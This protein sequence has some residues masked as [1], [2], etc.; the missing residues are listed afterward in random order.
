MRRA[1]IAGL[2][3]VLMTA[4]GVSGAVFLQ[5]DKLQKAFDDVPGGRVDIKVDEITPAEAGKPQTIMILGTDERLGADATPGQRPR[6]DTILL[7]RL[8]AHKESI[9]LMSIPRDF[10]V[11]IP[12]YSL[13]DKINA[14]FSNGG[15]DLTL[16]T[17]KALLSRPDRPFKV[18]HVVQVSFTGFRRMVDYLG[19][20]YVDIDRRYF[21]DVSGPGGYA[22]IDIQPGYQKL[23]GKDALDY[24]RF[25]HTD[26][27]LVRGARQQDFV[28]Q[29]LRQPGVRKRLTLSKSEALIRLVGRYTKVDKSLRSKKQLFSLFKLG[30]AVANKPIQEVPFGAGRIEDDGPSYL[31]ASTDAIDETVNQFLNSRPADKPR[32]TIKDTPAEK[33]AKRKARKKAKSAGVSGLEND[34][35]EGENMAIVAKRHLDFPFYYPKLRVVGSRYE[36]QLPRFYTIRDELGKKHRAYR[37]VFSLGQAGEYYGVQGMSWMKPPILDGP[38]ETDRLNGRRFRV[39]FD[40]KRV[41]LVAW[42]TDNAVYWVHNTLARTITKDRLLAIAGSLTRLGAR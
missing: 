3:V 42:K 11:S 13:S 37:S 24:V 2:L 25:R 34:A 1:A 22:T 40:G 14:A 17:V 21:N 10:K 20:A 15:A 39:Y 7:A 38:Y 29:M 41:R 26:N 5:V 8:D 35:S 4:A 16:K 6:S 9:T 23:C 32:V 27:D 30:L 12:G 28:R 18:N 31:T 33:A 36:D 19:C